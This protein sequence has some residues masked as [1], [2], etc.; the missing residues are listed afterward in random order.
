MSPQDAVHS[1]RRAA[2]PW[3]ASTFE[4]RAQ[5]CRALAAALVEDRRAGLDALR[6]DVG[7]SDADSLLTELATLPGYV[8]G[9]I[10][11]AKAAL[12]PERVPLSMLD[13]PGKKAVIE[14]VPR[15]VVAAITPWNYPVLQIV[16]PVI[17]A[18]L[19]GNSVVLKPSPYAPH[20]A[21]WFWRVA[22][23]VLGEGVIVRVEGGAE[24]GDA[25]IDLVDA[26]VFTGSVATGRRVAMRCAE[27]LIP[28]SV[29]LG[30][31]D[32][33]IVLADC[34]LPRTLAG[35]AFAA[36][37]NAGQDCASIERVIVVD[38]VADDLVKGLAAAAGRLRLV[39][40]GV[41]EV[42][43]MQNDAVAA[44]V[45]RHVTEAIADGAVLVG[46][47][48]PTDRRIPAIVL[49]RCRPGMAVVDEE[50]FGPV[51]AVIRVRDADAAV[52]MANASRFGL[53]GSV[54]TKDIPAGEALA[55]RLHVGIALVNN[56]GF[57]G[58]VPQIPWTGT[59]DT[60]TGVAASRHAYATFVR[61]RTIVVDRNSDPDLFWFPGNADL[62]DVAERVA[63]LQLGHYS[64]VFGLL[65][66]V[67][68]RIAAIRSWVTGPN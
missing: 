1:A 18:L 65:M 40:D 45:R 62:D 16:K 30:G 66:A 38:A 39:T 28:C 57:P 7:R 4:E 29:E 6:A 13:F 60:G 41:G 35:I 54:W 3:A 15:G 63:R 46:G 52:E 22:A 12:A 2:A 23:G 49:D 27:R 25:L 59:G 33:A 50:T 67:R 68:R 51:V 53:N 19:A 24:V 44:V 55:R 26:V 36:F 37:H 10:Q 20:A 11:V 5:R 43:P 48:V 14:A 8:A 34:D 61:R 21:A 47:N 9:A 31:K 58:V 17:P 32:A 64:V 42:P 56:H